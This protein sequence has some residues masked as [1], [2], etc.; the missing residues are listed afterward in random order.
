MDGGVNDD[1]RQ[2]DWRCE[3]DK[4]EVESYWSCIQLINTLNQ[5][6]STSLGQSYFPFTT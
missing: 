2:R 4:A 6:G 5:E 1:Q 3:R